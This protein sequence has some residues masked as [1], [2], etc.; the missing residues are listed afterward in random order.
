[1]TNTKNRAAYKMKIKQLGEDIVADNAKFAVAFFDIKGLKDI[2][3][4][5]GYEVGDRLLYEYARILKIVVGY[6]SV[7][8]VVGD[9]FIIICEGKTQYDMITYSKTFE[10]HL[11]QYHDIQEGVSLVVAKGYAV[12][13]KEKFNSYREVFLDAKADCDKDRTTKE[14]SKFEILEKKDSHRGF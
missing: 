6:N 12:Y 3:A 5:F 7:Y 13:D 2:S 8:H 14:P 1:M 4:H 11:V 10:E 9:E